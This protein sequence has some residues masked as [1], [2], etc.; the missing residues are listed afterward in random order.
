MKKDDL[1]NDYL[2]KT[3]VKFKKDLLDKHVLLS[4]RHLKMYFKF[5]S[6]PNQVKLKAVHDVS[7]DVMEGETFGIVGESGCGKTTTGRCIIRLYDIT[8]GSIYYKGQRISGGDQLE[9]QG[10]QIF[11]HSRA[12]EVQGTLAQR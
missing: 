7:F 1:N 6:W 8:S 11:P 4:V 9:P 5:G 12:G 3:K 2:F 10:N